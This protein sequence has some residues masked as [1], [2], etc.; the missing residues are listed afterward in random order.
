M[1]Y[2]HGWDAAELVAG[3]ASVACNRNA[4]LFG[5]SL[6]FHRVVRAA[7]QNRPQR[8]AEA[9]TFVRDCLNRLG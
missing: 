3:A 2:F 1:A 8:S 6:A 5:L 9:A 7:R 4:A